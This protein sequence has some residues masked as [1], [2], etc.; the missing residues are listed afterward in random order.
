M[1]CD[2]CLYAIKTRVKAKYVE[3]FIRCRKLDMP[4]ET[5]IACKYYE[6]DIKN[7]DIKQ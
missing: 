3:T 1:R 7:E 5:C 2:D 6:E 4:I